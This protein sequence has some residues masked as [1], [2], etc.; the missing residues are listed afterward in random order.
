MKTAR[1]NKDDWET[2][3]DFLKELKDEFGE[4]WDPC[5]LEPHGD[6]LV[7]PWKKKNFINPPYSLK[8]KRLFVEKAC[9][10]AKE[11][12]LCVCLLP[13]STSTKLFHD[14][15][16]PNAKEIRF[17]NGRIK[18]WG[19]NTK[20]IYV[21]NNSGQ[22]DNM[23]VIF[24]GRFGTKVKKFFKKAWPFIIGVFGALGYAAGERLMELF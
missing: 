7:L 15:I 14:V 11:G 2:P 10:E 24:D 3:A 23:L 9:E 6:S 17:I 1:Q 19:Y 20:G 21:T 12:K 22:A 18:F 13:V 4:M 8:L 5:P 16:K